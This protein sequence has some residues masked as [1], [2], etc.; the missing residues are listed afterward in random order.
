MTVSAAMSMTAIDLPLEI[1]QGDSML[2]KFRGRYENGNAPD[3]TT[4][5]INFNI[6]Y[7]ED[8]RNASIF[9]ASLDNG[10]VTWEDEAKCIFRVYIPNNALLNVKFPLKQPKQL[11]CKY[12]LSYSIMGFSDFNTFRTLFASTLTIYRI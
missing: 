2:L 8:S 11:I 6:S 3:L 1:V 4:A 12:N 7:T 5:A 9:E 10:L